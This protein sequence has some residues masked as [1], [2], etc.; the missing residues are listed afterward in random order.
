[1]SPER[2]GNAAVS[3]GG[4]TAHELDA[5]LDT[6]E[7]GFAMRMS[8]HR[9]A[10]LHEVVDVDRVVV[11]RDGQQIVGV[12]DSV[13]CEMT[14]PGPFVV[15]ATAVVGVAVRPT[16]RRQGRLAAMM[17]RQ[18]ADMRE[19]GERL[20]VL[21]SS[22]SRIYQRFGYGPATLSSRYAIESRD[23][24]VDDPEGVTGSCRMRLVDLAEART[25][26]PELL[27]RSQARRAGEVA[28]LDLG[29]DQVLGTGDGEARPDRYFVVCEDGSG[30]VGYAVYRIEVTVADGQRTRAVELLELC[31][32]TG[33]AYLTLWSYLVSIDLTTEVT[34]HGRPVDE[35]IRFALS[36]YRRMRTVRSGEHTYLR[37]LDVGWALAARR[38]DAEGTLSISVTDAT[39][40]WNEG[41]YT[42]RVG[43][44]G[45]A[46]LE[47][48]APV[49][50]GHASGPGADLELDVSVLGSIY[51]GGLRPGALALLGLVREL[52]PDAI[53]TA[54]RMFGGPEPPYCTTE[55]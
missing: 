30:P 14:V 48:S 39:C 37:L 38:Y 32:L 41:L 33:A 2:S 44:D 16:H 13:V 27:R 40:P 51:L 23:V 3:A 35:P 54:D 1:M 25:S 53:R 17:R 43:G 45:R 46:D 31:S 36:D 9:R 52:R 28:R 19:R 4:I 22:E 11:S 18:L 6:D 26:F 47:R 7:F 55:F 15:P 50:S 42:I 8:P 21:T 20:A 49:A 12:A 10:R 24:A 29:W 34:T 5:V